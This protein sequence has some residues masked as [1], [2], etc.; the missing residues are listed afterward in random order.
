MTCVIVVAYRRCM[1]KIVVA[2]T[3]ATRLLSEG[4][5]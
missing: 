2:G 1:G 5:A 4:M 3:C